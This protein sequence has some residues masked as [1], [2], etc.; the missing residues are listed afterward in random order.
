MTLIHL[1]RHAEVEN[2]HAVWYGR[3]PGFVL[4][5][6]GRRQAAALAEYFQ[7]HDMV[8]V[9][10]SPL[11]RAMQ[12]AEVIA[13]PKGL[14]VVTDEDL[15][16]SDTYLQGKPGSARVLR[17]P[18]NW[19]FF[20]NPFRPSWG[21]SYSS[22][23]ARMLEAVERIRERHARGE[24]AVVSHMTPILVA[25]MR[26]EGDRRPAWGAQPPCGK[27]SVTSLEFDGDKFVRTQY[28]D[29][30]RAVQ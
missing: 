29:V 23:R 28:V 6:R 9:Y 12:T 22:I 17:N 30:G 8:G 2:P 20:V 15:I 3:L 27:A 16:E 13:E 7:D 4:S 5:E 26:L 21:E 19:R 25:R 14:K 10:S 18:L 1:V 11:E 24:A